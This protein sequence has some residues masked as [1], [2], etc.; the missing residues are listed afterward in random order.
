MPWRKGKYYVRSAR[1]GD[2]IVTEYLGGG[3]AGLLAAAEDDRRRGRRQRRAHQIDAERARLELLEHPLE[4]L[5]AV[6]D[7]LVRGALVARGYHQ[8]DRGQWRKK[9]HEDPNQA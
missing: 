8:H 4:T 7:V 5:N 6:L 9:R 1:R 3:A 2:E